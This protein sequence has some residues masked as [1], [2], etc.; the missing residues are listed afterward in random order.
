M[1]CSSR[2]IHTGDKLINLWIHEVSR[3]FHDRLTSNEDQL[4]FYD[5]IIQLLNSAFKNK[6]FFRKELFEDKSII[7]SDILKL[8]GDKEYEEILD[9]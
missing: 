7:F 4:W 3:V 2:V 6:E 8:E 5:L 9:Q 1:M